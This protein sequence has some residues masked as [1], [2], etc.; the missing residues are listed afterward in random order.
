MFNVKTGIKLVCDPLHYLND[1]RTT[2]RS[3]APTHGSSRAPLD[4]VN[5]LHGDPSPASVDDLSLRHLLARQ[6]TSRAEDQRADP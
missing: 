3:L 2:E 5:C 1:A 6:M 4:S